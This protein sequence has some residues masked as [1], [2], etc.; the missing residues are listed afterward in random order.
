MS[1]AVFTKNY[2]EP[3]FC[4]REI[5]RYAG[6]KEPDGEMLALVRSCI[7]EMKPKLTY[8]VCYRPLQVQICGDSCDFGACAFRSQKL[9][10]N[11]Q[12][13][14]TAVLFAAT[15]GLEID[16]LIAKYGRISPSRA[17]I[18]QAIGAER[19]EALCDVFC[20]DMAR[21]YNAVARPRFSPGYGDL[22]LDSQRDIFSILAPEKHAGVFLTDSLL[23]SPSKSVTAIVGLHKKGVL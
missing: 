18:F 6:C 13:C 1:T 2:P 11:L 22:P 20:A 9:A 23:M 3:P 8:K 15:I 16:R 14:Q 7:E 4:E 17:W 19:I 10:K 12:N 5:L 21:E